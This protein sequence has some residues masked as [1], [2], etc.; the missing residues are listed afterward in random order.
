MA[1]E[2]AVDKSANSATRNDE[3]TLTTS[4]AQKLIGICVEL[5][6]LCSKVTGRIDPAVGEMIAFARDEALT[7]AH[8]PRSSEILDRARFPRQ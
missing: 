6:D 2:I 3:A 4:E 5:L 7:T 1:Y 8:Y